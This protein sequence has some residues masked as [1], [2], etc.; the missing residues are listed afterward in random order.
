MLLHLGAL[1]QADALAIPF[2]SNYF[3]SI[4]TSPPYW[5]LRKYSGDQGAEPL[6]LEA[7][8][9]QHIE[10]LVIIFREV[11]RV[12]RDD[13]VVWL[14]YG[15]CYYNHRPGKGSGLKK[16][17]I[18]RTN[19]EQPTDYS[20]RR[21][22]KFEGIGEG[23]LMLMPHRLAIALQQ[24]GWIVR[25]DLVWWKRN[26]MPESVAGWRWESKSCD[27]MTE[28]REAAIAANADKGIDRSRT[29]GEGFGK[30]GDIGADP[31]CPRCHGSGKVGDPVLKKGSWRHTRGHEY[32]FMLTQK[33]KY[34]CDQEVIRE[35]Y[36]EPLDRW[37]GDSKS[38]EEGF[39][40]D[41]E[42]KMRGLHRDREMRPSVGRNPRSVLDVP[43]SS[44]KG[45]HYATFP[46]KLIAP[47]IRASVPKR[48]CPECG[49]AWSPVIEKGAPTFGETSWGMEGMRHFKMGE[50]EM[51]E[52][53]LEMGSTLKHDVPR[54]ITSYRPTCD[55]GNEEHVPGIVLDIFGGS[56]TTGMVAKELMRRWVVMDISH[57]YLDEQAKV[58]T[59][60]GMPS[61][62][63]D[64]LP[65]F[66]GGLDEETDPVV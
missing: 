61:K 41:D 20:P 17:T 63:L 15:D 28:R 43:T 22:G 30:P 56:G 1:V 4:L 32:I 37:G 57:P 23:S 50:G 48:A 65:L 47:L 39:K 60:T 6:G 54:T 19:R 31:D 59:G 58:R 35:I 9:E 3:H 24:D 18:A 21:A 45:A 2:P 27:C 16:Q 25:N 10:R 34:H 38:T 29:Y 12:L 46:P 7:T 11:W 26:P 64:G 42:N 13:G 44:Y 66:S 53:S 8:P 55:C 36:T 40:G 49:M 51:V 62:A 5:G 14:N 52:T 33:M